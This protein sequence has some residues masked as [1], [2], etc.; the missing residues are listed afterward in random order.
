[1]LDF[2]RNL[3]SQS[4]LYIGKK[5]QPIENYKFIFYTFFTHIGVWP[6]KQYFHYSY[7]NRIFPYKTP[8]SGHDFT[9]LYGWIV[10]IEAVEHLSHDIDFYFNRNILPLFLHAPTLGIF[11]QFSFKNTRHKTQ[12]VQQHG[13]LN[14]ADFNHFI[15][16]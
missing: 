4:W 15:K 12:Q 2:H 11:E 5:T 13:E 9:D 8:F 7:I 6:S 16:K 3:F 1:M 14:M 10:F